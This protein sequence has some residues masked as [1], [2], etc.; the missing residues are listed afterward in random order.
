MV[1][2]QPPQMK[3]CRNIIAQ[4]RNRVS[5]VTWFFSSSI[6][7][8]KMRFPWRSLPQHAPQAALQAQP[9]R[10]RLRAGDRLGDEAQAAQAL[11][12]PGVISHRRVTQSDSAHV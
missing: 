11:R 6:A 8:G 7:S 4:R 12:Y 2:N 3:N 10:P 1:T 5:L 9:D